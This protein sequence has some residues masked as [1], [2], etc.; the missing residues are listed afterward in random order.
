MKIIISR[1]GFDSGYGGY[2]SPILPDGTLLSIPIPNSKGNHLSEYSYDNSPYVQ[3]TYEQVKIPQSTREYFHKNNVE[4]DNFKD[5][6]SQLTHG[7]P[8]KLNKEVLSLKEKQFCHLDPDLFTDAI[9]RENHEDWR[10]M[11]GQAK[12]AQGHLN[13][14]GVCPDDIFL[15]FGLFRHT[16]IVNGRLN[17]NCSKPDLH[18][19]FAYFQIE[20]ILKKG[21]EKKIKPWM[22]KHPHLDRVLWHSK[23]NAVYIARSKLRWN[24]ALSGYG[25]FKLNDALI[26]TETNPI[27]NPKR[28]LTIWKYNFL[29]EDIQISYHSKNSWK[30]EK[31]QSGDDIK[32][33]RSAGKGQEFVIKED[34]KFQ[35]RIRSLINK[36]GI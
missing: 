32:Y 1:K 8:I 31:N 13:K 10:A 20:L 2:P 15:F 19:I 9:K 33:F 27:V 22:K 11:F 6:L 28:N 34:T 36:Y 3:T 29:S 30:K 18:I 24:P 25:C 16:N 14:K 12:A 35:E 4:I 17:Y 5:L 7:F 26:L 23:N 21:D